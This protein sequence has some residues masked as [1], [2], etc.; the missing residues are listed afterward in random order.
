MALDA[1][2][3]LGAR[4][5]AKQFF[6]VIIPVYNR[7]SAILPT[8]KSVQT[9]TYD[10]FECLVIDD[11]SGDADALRAVVDGLGDDRF[12]YVWR[13]N[14][15]GGAARNTGISAAR[16][17]WISFL[18]S[19]DFFYPEKLKTIA[20]NLSRDRSV[21]I[22]SH[23]ALV[24]RGGN[25][26][27]L[28]P[29]RLPRE[30]ETVSELMF[31]HREFLQTSTL[32]VR[33]ELARKVMFDPQLRKAQDVD[34]M[35]RLERAGATYKCL[36]ETLS[37]WTDRPA[38][39]RVGSP[40]RPIDVRRWYESEGALLPPKT[41]RAFEATYLSYEIAK[42]SPVESLHFIL[43]ALVTGAIN[44][45]M[46]VVSFLRAFLSPELYRPL[47]NRVVGR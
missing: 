9:Q 8:L 23:R 21:D 41:R 25:V 14:G 28:R 22:W 37:I 2:I 34:F 3:P 10:D 32:T 45:K 15:G 30:G 29:T 27:F 18:D 26:K 39:D 12:R 42:E 40:R 47:V 19:D 11:G 16:G 31:K 7:A 43:R 35:V 13:A 38:N 4:G 5:S 24:E 20:E 17:D 36:P 44:P 1:V 6:T 33:A 46:A